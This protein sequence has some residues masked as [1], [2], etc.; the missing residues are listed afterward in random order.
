MPKRGRRRKKTR[1][2]VVDNEN[3]ASA[4]ESAKDLKVPRSLVI[5][6]GKVE[7]EVIELVADLR[8]LM[9][10]YTAASFK[11]DAKNRKMT[12]AHYAKELTGA[13]GVTHLMAI[14]QNGSRLN[15]RLARTPAGP[16]LTFKLKQFSLIKQVRSVQRRPFDSPAAYNHPPIVVTNNFGDATAAPHVKLMRITFQNMFPAVNVATVKLADCRRVVLFNFMRRDFGDQPRIKED[17]DAEEDEEVEIRHYAIK[18]TPVG[19]NRKV[20]R[21][22]QAKI[23]NLSKLDDV[24]DY[25]SGQTAAGSPAA[26][27]TSG[28]MSDSEPEDETSHVVLAQKYT[29]RGNASAQKSALKLVELG[30]RL[31]LKLAKVERGLASGDVMYHAYIKKSL[32]EVKKQRAKIEKEAMDKK[33]R[34]EEQ[35][36]NVERKNR[37]KEEKR[38]AKR[39]KKEHRELV[40]MEEL[41]RGGV[42]AEDD[43]GSGNESESSSERSDYSTDGS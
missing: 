43:S 18:A 19:V 14:S 5:R 33:R 7:S 1:T 30:P 29:G 42:G 28:A 41:R 13:M 39:L 15:L 24:A 40:A 12:L 9:L 11:E 37:E 6:R 26:P 16:T 31:R 32:S 25:I 36:A 35:E 2:H 20:R 17:A 8:R 4:L 21:L 3:A 27:A 38:E 34:R 10:P 22:I 23:P